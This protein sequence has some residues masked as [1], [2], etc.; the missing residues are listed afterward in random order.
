MTTVETINSLVQAALDT[1][2]GSDERKVAADALKEDGRTIEAMLLLGSDPCL[3]EGGNILVLTK[4]AEGARKYRRTPRP[5]RPVYCTRHEDRAKVGEIIRR[6]DGIYVVT[7]SSPLRYVNDDW[8][9]DNDAWSQYKEG[10]G[11]YSSYTAVPVMEN[12]AERAEREA[13]EQAEQKKKNEIAA[14]KQADADRW[15]PFASLPNI[16]ALPDGCEVKDWECI[17]DD[18]KGSKSGYGLRRFIG[19]EASGLKVAKV[20]NTAYDDWREWYHVPQEVIDRFAGRTKQRERLERLEVCSRFSDYREKENLTAEQLTAEW[21]RLAAEYLERY[22]FDVK[23]PGGLSPAMK[24]R[25]TFALGLVPASWTEAVRNRIERE[26]TAVALRDRYARTGA[27]EDLV[28]WNKWLCFEGAELADKRQAEYD[29]ALAEWLP[30]LTAEFGEETAKEIVDSVTHSFNRYWADV[31]ADEF[32]SEAKKAR[33]DAAKKAS[34]AKARAARKADPLVV[35]TGD[36]YSHRDAL[37]RITGSSRKKINGRW[38]WKVPQ[39][40]VRNLPRG[41]SYEA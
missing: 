13:K 31:A 29:A 25:A 38:V 1:A 10:P 34:Q 3:I 6:K 14:Q 36:T 24:A 20:T 4:V 23:L 32:E 12:N 39:S 22:G 41:L 18:T 33:E 7:E 26:P 27:D 11:R 8:I 2:V 16:Y 35:V 37:G 40:Q 5:G 19:T 15:A 30:K 17:Y 28:A 9:E 21:D